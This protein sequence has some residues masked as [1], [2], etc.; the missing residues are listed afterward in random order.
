MSQLCVA[1]EKLSDLAKYF[2]DGV[3]A[4]DLETT[5]LSPITDEIIEIAAIRWIPGKKTEQFQT[6]VNPGCAIPDFSTE[7]HGID[8][9]MVAG[10]P[11]IGTVLPEFMNFARGLP[12]V[13]HNAVFDA[14]F[15]IK[16]LHSRSL[17]FVD[18]EIYDSC[19][20]ARWTFSSKGSP[21]HAPENYKLDTLSRFF[22]L[23]PFKHHRA[24]D[25]AV[26]C[27]EIFGR[28]MTQFIAKDTNRTFKDISYL[29]NLHEFKNINSLDL[30]KRLKPLL[31]LLSNRKVVNILY[32]GKRKP[33]GLRPIRPVGFLPLPGGIFLRA[34]CLRSNKMKSFG[35]ERIKAVETVTEEC[36]H[37]QLIGEELNQ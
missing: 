36:E 1:D 30:P 7:I 33:K 5:G 27:L 13:A 35:L 37:G 10:S 23:D 6:L 14:G 24:L 32:K 8:D 16:G 22:G 2:P 25:D 29:F 20:F 18:T 31:P 4:L 12:M 28:T 9:Q 17:P 34:L 11:E 21:E 15:L 26:A 19:H 3:C